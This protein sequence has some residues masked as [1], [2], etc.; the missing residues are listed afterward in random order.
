MAPAL[1]ARSARRSPSNCHPHEGGCERRRR[2]ERIVRHGRPRVCRSYLKLQLTATDSGGLTDT[3]TVRLDP[4]T[5]LLSFDSTPTCLHADLNGTN[6][7]SAFLD[8]TVI[9]NSVNGLDTAPT[10]QTIA[11]GTYDFSS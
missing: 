1:E 8:E 7:T 2:G 6:A 11:S 3:R 4:K 9:Q 10:P 5:V